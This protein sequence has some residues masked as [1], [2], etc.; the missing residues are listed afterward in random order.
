M[1]RE[2]VKALTATAPGSGGGSAFSNLVLT[3][4]TPAQLSAFVRSAWRA[5]RDASRA[6]HLPV[7]QPLANGIAALP[8][9]PE[10][11]SR[12]MAAPG[13]SIV[14]VNVPAAAGAPARELTLSWPHLI[15]AYMVE[16]TGAIEIFRRI[17]TEWNSDERLPY[18]SLE[19]QYWLRNTEELFFTSPSPDFHS[20]TSELRPHSAEIRENAYQRL[21]GMDLSFRGVGS[22]PKPRPRASNNELMRTFERLL[23][24]VWR[25]YVNRATSTSENRTDRQAMRELVRDMREML[26]ARRTNGTLL[27]EEYSAIVTASWFFLTVDYENFVTQNLNA[28]APSAANR[29]HKIAGLVGMQPARVADSYFHLADPLSDLFIDIED[30]AIEAVGVEVLY[31]DATNPTVTNDLQLI[32]THWSNATGRS[33]KDITDVRPL[34]VTVPAAI[35]APTTSPSVLNRIA[36]VPITA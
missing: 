3:Q 35:G 19:T 9:T 7:L 2:L 1:F 17:V 21:L 23:Y 31:D 26:T 11:R 14:P 22:T 16:N 33:V 15:Y 25:G 28:Q 30:G 29:L 24:E 6:W 34:Q 32:I 36:G 12:A 27:R 10:I 20:L 5:R 4:Y 18:A 8:G 13:R